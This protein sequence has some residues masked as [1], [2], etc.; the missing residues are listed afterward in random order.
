MTIFP[1]E[2]QRPNFLKAFGGFIVVAAIA[3]IP[4]AEAQLIKQN[5][6]ASLFDRLLLYVVF[7]GAISSLATFFFWWHR[8]SRWGLITALLIIVAFA[9]FGWKG[10]AS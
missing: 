1:S 7:G 10:A 6:S 8:G 2:N 4:A 5:M 3:A 9:F